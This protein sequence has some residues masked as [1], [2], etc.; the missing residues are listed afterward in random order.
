MEELGNPSSIGRGVD[1]PDR[2]SV[3]ALGGARP[4]PPEPLQ[5]LGA[6]HVLQLGDRTW[7]ERDL[8]HG[9][10]FP[11]RPATRDRTHDVTTFPG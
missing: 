2:V 10:A 1:V 6:S 7:G 8:S 5:V 9:K 11:V 3:E 4:C